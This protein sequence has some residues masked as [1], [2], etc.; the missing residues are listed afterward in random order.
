MNVKNL[1]KYSFITI[2]ILLIA[3]CG[4]GQ[5]DPGTDSFGGGQGTNFERQGPNQGTVQGER[6]DLEQKGEGQ[7]SQGRGPIMLLDIAS[8]ATGLDVE[9]I[10]E[11]AADGA[12]LAEIITANDGDVEAVKAQMI[13]AMEDMPRLPDDGDVEQFVDNMLNN[14]L[15]QRNS[16]GRSP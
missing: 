7:R 6:S 8:E 13:E 14:P 1:L 3:A 12:T 2:L 15:G 4:T 10:R 9:T 11:Q 5:S 16:G